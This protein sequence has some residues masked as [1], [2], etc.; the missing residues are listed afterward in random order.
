MAGTGIQD[1]YDDLKLGN[2]ENPTGT[3]AHDAHFGTI[4]DRSWREAGNND[5]PARNLL[6]AKRLVYR[7]CIF[8]NHFMSEASDGTMQPTT[9]SGVAEPFGTDFLVTLGPNSAKPPGSSAITKQ[10]AFQAAT[11]MHELGH[12]LGLGHGGPWP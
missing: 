6:G 8:G 7:Y 5:A 11:F 3:D 9:S 4:A 12:N 2:P 1:D 10:L